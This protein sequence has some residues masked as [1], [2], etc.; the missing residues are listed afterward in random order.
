MSTPMGNL[1]AMVNQFQQFRQTFQGDPKQ[2]VMELVN[3]GQI[4]Q[5]Q[6]TQLQNTASQLQSLFK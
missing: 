6:L 2:K 3:S 5:E 1:M 4:S